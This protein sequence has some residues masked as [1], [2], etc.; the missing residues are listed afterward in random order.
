[1]KRFLPIV[2]LL[3]TG[4][5]VAPAAKAD[6]THRLTSSTA[7]TVDAAGSAAT[8]IGATYAVSGTNIEVSDAN[9]AA[10]GGL[11]APT[12]VTAAA[13]MTDGTY[14]IHD[15]T[16]AWSFSESFIQ[17]D[18]VDADGTTVTFDVYASDAA[19]TA[20][21]YGNVEEL[22]AFGQV[23]TTAGGQAASLAGTIKSDGTITLTAGGA[24]TT[25]TGQFVSEVTIR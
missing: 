20:N 21:N 8:R 16:A 4:A 18:V 10:F 24:G 17:G 2:M 13:A 6:L 19:A 11:T 9:G 15:D 1:M 23:T 14:A 12:S 7:L 3:M 22:P 5:V 25:A